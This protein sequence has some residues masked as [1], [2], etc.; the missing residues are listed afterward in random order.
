MHMRERLLFGCGLALIRIVHRPLERP[1]YA[2]EEPLDVRAPVAWRYIMTTHGR[3][4][5]GGLYRILRATMLAD[6]LPYVRHPA[7]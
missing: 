7:V 3:T 4:N 2:T 6:V 1:S 5:R